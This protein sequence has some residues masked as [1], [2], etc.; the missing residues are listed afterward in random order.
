MGNR[1]GLFIA[2][3]GFVVLAL[4]VGDFVLARRRARRSAQELAELVHAYHV[5][6][7]RPPDDDIRLIEDRMS[8][9]ETASV[10]RL[11]VWVLVGLVQAIVG[12]VACLRRKP[13]S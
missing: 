5:G 10:R 3:L 11:Q 7:P 4:A 6:T 8:R 9:D 12:V 13:P 2:A 1:I